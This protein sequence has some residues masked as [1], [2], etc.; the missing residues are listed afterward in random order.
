[1]VTLPVWCKCGNIVTFSNETRCEDCY[2]ADQQRYDGQSQ[3]VDTIHLSDR[4]YAELE[5]QGDKIISIFK[6]GTSND[7]V[8][9]PAPRLPGDSPR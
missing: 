8:Q 9:E 6:G 2:S 4:E 1:M 5:R 7:R 3:H